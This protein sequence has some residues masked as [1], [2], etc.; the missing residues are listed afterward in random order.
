MASIDLNPVRAGLVH[1]PL[2]FAWSSHAHYVGQRTDK[3][4]TPHPF[5]WTLG[6][7]PF[8]RETA[9]AELVQGGLGAKEQAAMTDAALRGWA[10]GSGA[11]LA[12]LQRQTPRRLQQATPGRPVKVGNTKA[13]T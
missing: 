7:T 12:E 6:N 1:A 8:S 13:Q 3:L 2:D 10:L 9:Y 4:V 5:L 11:F